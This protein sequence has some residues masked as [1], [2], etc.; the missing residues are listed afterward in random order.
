MR[1]IIEGNGNPPGNDMWLAYSMNKEDMWIS[2]IP[3]PIQYSVKGEVNDNFN[4]LETGGAVTNWN[5]YSP[6]WAPVGV[7]N[8]PSSANKSLLLEDKDPFDYARAIR[9]FE[10]TKKCEI[11]VRVLPKQINGGMLDID[12]C[13]RFGNRPVRISFTSEGNIQTVDGNKLV[14]LQGYKQDQWYTLKISVD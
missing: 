12:I 6:K 3:V 2:R 5:I 4:N 8:F 9:V 13:D 1:G 14:I 11:A 10:E 7:A